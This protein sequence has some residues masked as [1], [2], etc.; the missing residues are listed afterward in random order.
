[1]QVLV[2]L[3]TLFNPGLSPAQGSS[4]G[5]QDQYW[6]AAFYVPYAIE[7][8]CLNACACVCV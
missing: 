6:V 5:A 7:F 1:M 8:L 2:A 4:L 3:F